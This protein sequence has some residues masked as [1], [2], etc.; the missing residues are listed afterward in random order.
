MFR[1]A[2]ELYALIVLVIF[3]IVG[4]ALVLEKIIQSLIEKGKLPD[5]FPF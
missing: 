2:L 4:V 1:V 5:D 3:A